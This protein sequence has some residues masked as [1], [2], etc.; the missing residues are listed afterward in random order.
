M[1]K[2]TAAIVTILTLSVAI[3]VS[4]CSTPA[5]AKQSAGITSKDTRAL[6]APTEGVV[7]AIKPRAEKVEVTPETLEVKAALDGF[8]ASIADK[9]KAKKYITLVKSLEDD[10][11]LS[12][13]QRNE[14]GKKFFAE[15]I[16]QF[17][18]EK[19]SEDDAFYL[20]SV[21]TIA[22]A[23]IEENYPKITVPTDAIVIKD[24]LAVI[25]MDQVGKED[26]AGATTPPGTVQL[27]K[28][29]GKWLITS[30]PGAK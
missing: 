19:I 7:G 22:S 26:P 30:F 25:D 16:K 2:S 1:K 21:A 17:D 10:K 24:G 4:A 11:S 6:K 12:I 5:P 15:D 13:K 14:K 18:L 23:I 27:V 9:E 29:D 28:K 8:Y 20:L 3:G